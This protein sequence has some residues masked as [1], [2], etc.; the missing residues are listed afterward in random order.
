MLAQFEGEQ[1]SIMADAWRR[2]EIV[3]PEG[4]TA[5]DLQSNVLTA[6]LNIAK[7]KGALVDR[8]ELT[9]AGGKDLFADLRAVMLTPV[10]VIVS[11]GEDPFDSCE[12]TP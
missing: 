10:Q 1:R 12:P 8:R 5:P 2:L 7:A 9:G 6:S 4:R 11:D 3:D